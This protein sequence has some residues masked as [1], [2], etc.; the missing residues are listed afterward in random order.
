MF[1]GYKDSSQPPDWGM[2][3]E[4]TFRKDYNAIDANGWETYV[5]AYSLQ[6]TPV[7]QH[8]ASLAKARQK[9]SAD[10]GKS[11]VITH[12]SISFLR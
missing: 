12:S 10:F 1:L 6:Q 2:V 4:T 8:L 7:D 3:E 5:G 9:V 11:S